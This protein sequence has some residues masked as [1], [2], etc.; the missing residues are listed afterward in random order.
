[1]KYKMRTILFFVGMFLF[2]IEGTWSIF[3]AAH[4]NEGPEIF[5]L[6]V[7]F[8]FLIFVTIFA[9]RTYGLVMAGVF[10]VMVDISSV[11][12]IGVYT[13]IY[14]MLIF[15]LTIL[16]KV[17]HEN[18]YIAIG[19]SIS[20]VALLEI[21]MYEFY[22]AT[23]FTTTMAADA[24]VMDRLIPTVIL[25]LIVTLIVA[26]PFYYLCKSARKEIRE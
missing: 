2:A 22:S 3:A 10:G 20:G 5:A 25:N 9:D 19:L 14:P 13:L 1:M 26:A 4:L 11:G 15:G 24:F 12:F 16:L 23:G 21:V 18:I 6:R 7:L 8:I 17:I